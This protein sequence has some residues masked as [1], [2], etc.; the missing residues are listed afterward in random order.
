VKPKDEALA[1]R[2]QWFAAANEQTLE[3]LPDFLKTLA[4][5]EFDY[6][7]ICYAVAAAAIAAAWAIDRS[8]NGGIT[9][10]Q[11]SAVMWE[12]ITEW[13]QLKGPARLLKWEDMLYP[14]QA[15]KFITIS[16]ETWHWLQE[17]AK[18]KLEEATPP[19]FPAHPDV[20]AHWKSIEAG[21]VPFGYRVGE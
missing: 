17:K 4:Q 20:L 9:G 8:P 15:D 11:A 6:N 1:L 19:A 18:E 13:C 2:E 14:Q 3:T 7:T 16:P 5:F 21:H 10:F 12:F